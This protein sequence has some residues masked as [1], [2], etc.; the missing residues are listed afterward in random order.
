M[1]AL[2]ETFV[3]IGLRERKIRR[4]FGI[5]ILSASIAVAVVFILNDLSPAWGWI[6]LPFFYQGVRFILD[7]RTGTC[8]LK[9]ELGQEK[10]DAWFSMLGTKIENG[11][12]VARIR[13]ISRK[14]LWQAGVA[15]LLLSLL[16]VVLMM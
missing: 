14:A 12:R 8:P 4:V 13:S 15:A 11:E 1:V 3:N 16:T 7:Y 2:S 6:L 10:L 9:A 5:G